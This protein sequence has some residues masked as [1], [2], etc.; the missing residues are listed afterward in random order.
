MAHNVEWNKNICSLKN[1]END[2]EKQQNACF[3]IYIREI[4]S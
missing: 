1:D 2:T 4:I 3:T